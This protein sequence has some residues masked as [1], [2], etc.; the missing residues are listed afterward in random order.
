MVAAPVI[1][2]SYDMGGHIVEY[3]QKVEE[4]R[5]E[6]VMV[7][8]EG[9]CASACTLV[10]GLPKDKLCAGPNAK[11]G[12]HKASDFHGDFQLMRA[13][14]PKV[15]A[16]IEWNGGLRE[17]VVWATGIVARHMIGACSDP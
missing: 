2:I 14:P 11:L 15:R 16:W 13:Y 8:I 12:F 17:E 7:R 6:G 1:T 9:A 3:Q 4:W 5:R 10:L